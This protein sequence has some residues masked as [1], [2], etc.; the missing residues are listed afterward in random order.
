M[1]INLFKN[2]IEKGNC[3]LMKIS[4][5]KALQIAAFGSTIWLVSN[6]TKL[7]AAG[8]SSI[9]RKR[10]KA[11]VIGAGMSG[12][13]AAKHLLDN[14]FDVTILEARERPGGRISTSK[15]GSI[16]VDMGASWIHGDSQLNPLMK[17]VDKY[18][19]KTAVT[20]WD[21]TW[22]YG[23]K[24]I[25]IEDKEYNSIER[26]SNQ[27]IQKIYELQESS[28]ADQSMKIVIEDLISEIRAP[29]LI[30]NG[31]K[32]LL[33][34]DIEGGY[35]ADYKDLSLWYWDD[36]EGFEGNDIFLLDGYGSLIKKMIEGVNI[37]YNVKV[38][39]IKYSEEGVL[40]SGEWGS[41]KGDI[42]IVTVPLGVLKNKSINFVP[43]LTPEK[44]QSIERLEMGTLNKVF[45]EFDKRFWPTKA[46]R[47]GH[48]TGDT[49][50]SIE[51][52]PARPGLNNRVLVA[53]ISGDYARSLERKSKEEVANIIISQIKKMFPRISKSNLVDILIT[54]WDS[55]SFTHGSY[56]YI[57]P[58]ASL[59][60]LEILSKPIGNS[61]L[62]AGEATSRDYNA[63]VH[64][65]YLS[66]LR[67]ASQA[68]LLNEYTDL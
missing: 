65:A 11:I 61:L 26:K 39:K 2:K 24:G 3:S 35:A 47:L 32:W 9:N 33:S 5:R 21:Q 43:P 46:H 36:G 40:I 66:G 14:N 1:T 68:I 4:R 30:K 15:I 10:K 31:V 20:N 28:S 45:I 55:D 13:T 8:T 38:D 57:P 42:A 27:I 56:S 22:L 41:V 18:N 29:S 17:L 52:L 64:G 58:N 37:E 6:Q 25:V 48:I 62:F 12:I 16:S 50:A 34:V 7:I 59:D 54:R 19:L 53:Y 23:E 67:A 60:D 63:T 49:N 51:F 44:E